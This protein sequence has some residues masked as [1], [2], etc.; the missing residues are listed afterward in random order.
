VDIFAERAKFE[1]WCT[2]TMQGKV[3]GGVFCGKVTTATTPIG[4]IANNGL[5]ASSANT[6][7][8]NKTPVTTTAQ[9]PGIPVT[10]SNDSNSNY[11]V[12]TTTPYRNNRTTEFT[13]INNFNKACTAAGGKPSTMGAEVYQCVT[14]K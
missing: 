9:F 4:T 3:S 7:V 1:A 12:L 10:T 11:F 2:S 14:P 6:T 5:N 8:T 13:M